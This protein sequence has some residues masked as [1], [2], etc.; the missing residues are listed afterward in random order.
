[1]GSDHRDDS[2]ILGVDGERGEGEEEGKEPPA[3]GLPQ[4]HRRM[5]TPEDLSLTTPSSGTITLEPSTIRPYFWFPP[6]ADVEVSSVKDSM[7]IGLPKTTAR[8]DFGLGSVGG[9]S[10][11]AEPRKMEKVGVGTMNMMGS[12]IP[13]KKPKKE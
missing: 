5:K 4:L 6:I 10:E 13:R 9:T 3:L 11:V 8:G 7:T 2:E 1:M 12:S